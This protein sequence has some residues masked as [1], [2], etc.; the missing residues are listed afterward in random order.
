MIYDVSS[1]RPVA[2]DSECRC[3]GVAEGDGGP[4][5]PGIGACACGRLCAGARKPGLENEDLD[6]RLAALER[7][8][9]LAKASGNREG[10][11]QGYL[12]VRF[13]R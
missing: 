12:Y 7:A 8:A 13:W 5:H 10:R 9:E 6:V 2:T 3:V 11:L 4:E 1:Q